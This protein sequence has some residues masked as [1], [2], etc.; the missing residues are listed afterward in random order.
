MKAYKLF[1]DQHADYKRS[2]LTLQKYLIEHL[3]GVFDITIERRD[4]PKANPPGN[5][6]V[7][8][9]Y[10]SSDLIILEPRFDDRFA[11]RMFR[12]KNLSI[13]PWAYS[14]D[15]IKHGNLIDDIKSSAV[16]QSASLYHNNVNES[17]DPAKCTSYKQ[18]LLSLQ[19]HM[20]EALP[21]GY[22]VTIGKDG[23]YND[24]IVPGSLFVFVHHK[25]FKDLK[26]NR[27]R[28]EPM[29]IGGVVHD[30]VHLHFIYLPEHR[31]IGCIYSKE[32]VNDGELVQDITE[33]A[34]L[35]YIH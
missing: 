23:F 14:D 10:Q 27:V 5:M 13:A 31:V 4:V 28:L 3:P 22:D 32:S 12:A 15:Q 8:I 11:V 2:L 7:V 18:L 6:F 16:Y 24:R 35:G 25:S 29:M 9:S 19:Q 20:I 1:E 26:N 34:P 21:D 30:S 33:G 17:W